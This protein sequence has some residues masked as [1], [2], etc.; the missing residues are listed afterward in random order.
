M[1]EAYAESAKDFLAKIEEAKKSYFRPPEMTEAIIAA[2][3]KIKPLFTEQRDVEILK[4]RFV[5]DLTLEKIAEHYG[6][7]RERIRQKE[8]Q[9]L[10]L[11]SN[12]K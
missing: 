11:L 12:L 4:M 2:L 8:K 5:D 9:L 6:V 7:T 1:L 10:T 3:E